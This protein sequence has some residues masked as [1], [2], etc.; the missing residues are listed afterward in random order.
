MRFSIIIPVLNEEAALED[1]L[2]PLTDQCAQHDYELLIVDGGST[3]STTSIA[4]RYGKVIHSP[5]G[6]A[7]Q[8][9]AGAALAKCDVLLFL[10]ADTRLPNEAF[11][12]IEQAL[13]SSDVIGGAFRLCFNC[14]RWTYRLVAF[15]T[16]LRSRLGTVF[17]GDQ[18]YFIRANSF[19]A[20][21]GYP[22][23]PLMEDLE[24][25]ARLRKIGKVI[26][27]PLFVTTSARRHQKIGLFRTVL[28][29]WY[30][31]TLYKFG[32]SP[33]QLQRLYSDIR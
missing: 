30:L 31:R 23:Q 4:Q 5:G 32:V 25:I 3:D 1:H 11:T 12:A 27:L 26:L 16:N 29:M 33:A 8:M 10:H 18:A 14:D 24:I 15:T 19:H 2:A 28:F 20:V 21:G 17:T 22:D 7:A 6:R 9:N 13:A